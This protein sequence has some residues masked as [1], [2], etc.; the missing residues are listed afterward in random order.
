M[1]Y[2]TK[3]KIDELKKLGV[4]RYIRFLVIDYIQPRFLIYT[5]ETYGG[6]YLIFSTMSIDLNL[7]NKGTV[8]MWY[9]C[10]YKYA[11]EHFL[12]KYL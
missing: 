2:N 9:F 6:N 1:L 8:K 11:L 4:G 7:I 3:T 12:N 5:K 10:C